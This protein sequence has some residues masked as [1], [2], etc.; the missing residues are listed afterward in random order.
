MQRHNGLWFEEE[1]TIANYS[2]AQIQRLLQIEFGYT[3][4]IRIDRSCNQTKNNS[5]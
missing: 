5:F 2:I 1:E 4:S 3:N